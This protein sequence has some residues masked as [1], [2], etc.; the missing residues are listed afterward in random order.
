MTYFSDHPFHRYLS[1]VENP[2]QFLTF[3]DRPLER[4][5]WTNT[6]KTDP[7]RLFQILERGGFAP[8]LLPWH[9]A[10]FRITGH[11]KGLGSHWAF[12]AGFFHIQEASSIIPAMLMDVRPGM[13]VLDLCAA[14][15]NKTAQAAVALGNRGTVIAND[16]VSGRLSALRSTA[17]RLG[18]LNITTVCHDGTRFPRQAGPFDRV[19]VDAPCS[20]G[21]F[22]SICQ[23]FGSAPDSL[24]GTDGPFTRTFATPSGSGPIS[25]TPGAS[26]SP[27]LSACFRRR[28]QN[29]EPLTAGRTDSSRNYWKRS[30]GGAT[31]GICGNGLAF[32]NRPSRVWTGYT[33]DPDTFSLW[34]TTTGCR[35]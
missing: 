18:L 27:S 33:T 14:P 21:W 30:V 7:K 2:G 12:M 22:P 28:R 19:M 11:H 10:A 5:V 17:A 9:P 31:S 3:V 4:F 29:R 1:L 25:T 13:R 6:I 26:L 34:P 16:A 32:Q 8:Q 35:P 24:D 15:G 23:G 20:R